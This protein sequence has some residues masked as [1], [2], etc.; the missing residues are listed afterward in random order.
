MMAFQREGAIADE[1]TF[2]THD[3]LFLLSEL[4]STDLLLCHGLTSTHKE[5]GILYELLAV[6]LKTLC[7]C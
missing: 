1:A 4:L 6:A 7:S 2:S 3:C 5:T